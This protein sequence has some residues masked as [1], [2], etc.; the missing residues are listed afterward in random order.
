MPKKIN[1]KELNSK[2]RKSIFQYRKSFR[3]NIP[4]VEVMLQTLKIH[5]KNLTKWLKNEN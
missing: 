3:Q 1:F 2:S 5:K 4:F